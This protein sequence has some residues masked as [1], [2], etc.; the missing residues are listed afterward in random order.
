MTIPVPAAWPPAM[1]VVMST[2]AGSTAST[3]ASVDVDP[4]AGNDTAVC[5]FDAG[6]PPEPA[7]CEPATD[8]RPT[9]NTNTAIAARALRIGRLRATGGGCSSKSG[10]GPRV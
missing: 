3:I 7:N 4:V 6:D 8:P 10:G 1:V 2:T 9:H 5:R